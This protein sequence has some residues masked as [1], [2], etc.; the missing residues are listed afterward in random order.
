MYNCQKGTDHDNKLADHVG[1]FA[2]WKEGHPDRLLAWEGNTSIGSDSDGGEVM[3]RD[4]SI[5]YVHAFVK[6]KVLLS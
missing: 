3:F 1:I 4:R 2:G 6:P 5:A